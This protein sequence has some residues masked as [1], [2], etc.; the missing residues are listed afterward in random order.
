M[1]ILFKYSLSLKINSRFEHTSIRNEFYTHR[2]SNV[3][4]NGFYINV[5]FT[6][7]FEIIQSLSYYNIKSHYDR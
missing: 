6:D 4:L 3:F 1:S 7:F 2:F 5:N